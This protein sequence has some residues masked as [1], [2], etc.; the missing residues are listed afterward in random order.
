[1]TD[2]HTTFR[3]C[4]RARYPVLQLTTFEECR[5]LGSVQ[6]IG[7]DMKHDVY[8]WSMASGVTKDSKSVA[9]KSTDLRVALDFCE[10]R[11]RQKE[12]ALF[13]FCDA[14]AVLLPSTGAVYRRRLREFANNIRT[15]GYRANVILL[16]PSAEIPME[17]QKDVT[18][19]DFPLP[20]R[21]LLRS[22]VADFVE[23]HR[24]NPKLKIDLDE[25]AIEQLAEAALGLTLSEVENCLA[26]ALVRQLALNEKDVQ[27]LLE[28]K[29]QTIRKSG[30]LEYVDTSNFALEQ[31]GGLETLKRWLAL[32]SAAFSPEAKAFGVAAPKGVLLTGVPGCGKSLTAKSVAASWKLPLLK[33]DMGRVFQGVVG[34]SE[35][36]VRNALS[37]AEAV[38]PAILWID[39]IEKGL[40]G[41]GGGGGDGG[42]AVRVFGTLLTWMQEKKSPVFVLATANDIAALPPELL[43]KGRFDEIFFVD[44]PSSAE[45]EAILGLQIKNLKRPQHS[46]DLLR[47]A[48]LSGES[49]LGEGVRLSGAEIEAW[50]QDALLEAYRRRSTGDGTADLDMADFE[51]TLRRMVPMARMRRG[52]IGKLREWAGENAVGA[53]QR[54]ELLDVSGVEGTDQS[55]GR[56]L[57][58]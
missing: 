56:A 1:M 22:A 40:A 7:T 35:A 38:A 21:A 29:Q 31:V 47:L 41:A 20:D 14:H 13:V 53:S 19:I 32:R 55:G 4:L 10:D 37:T 2:F 46:F 42:T 54:I 15:Q 23:P 50:C 51:Q 58:F 34:S 43:R 33:L 44:L 8:V 48:Q 28:E 3:N 12:A 6:A 16:G 5:A 17:L 39:E 36:N 26:K 25:R 45:R 27:V 11:A 18:L 30:I 9:E 24:S 57:D 52:D 49:N